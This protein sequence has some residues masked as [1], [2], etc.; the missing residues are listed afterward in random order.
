MLC[1]RYIKGETTVDVIVL[2]ACITNVACNITIVA[3][4]HPA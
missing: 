1:E 4:T 2:H 3:S